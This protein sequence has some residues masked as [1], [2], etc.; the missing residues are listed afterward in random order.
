MTQRAP[1]RAARRR[2]SQRLCR[3]AHAGRGRAAGRLAV[4]PPRD[5]D[6]EFHRRGTGA[7]RP[8][9]RDAATVPRRGGYDIVVTVTGPRQTLVTRRKE[10]VLGIWVNVDFA[11]L[12]ERAVLSRGAVEPAAR[13]HR[14]RRDAAPAAARPRQY[15]AAAADRQRH[16]RRRARRSVPRAFIRLKSEHEL[17]QRGVQRRHLPHA[18]AVPRRDPLP[19][20][21]PVGTYEVDVKLFADGA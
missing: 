6:L 2:C 5:G 7:V 10:R 3:L 9:E 13:R 1:Y 19:A 14:Q 15:P 18:D 21:V 16:R 8:V 4:Q 20:E 17:Y 12:R 11:R